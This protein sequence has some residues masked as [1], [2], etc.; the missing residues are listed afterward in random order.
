MLLLEDSAG[1]HADAVANRAA[2]FRSLQRPEQTGFSRMVMKSVANANIV[3]PN[4]ILLGRRSVYSPDLERLSRVATRTLRGLFYLTSGHRLPDDYI[5]RATVI[6]D[7]D[8]QDVNFRQTLGAAVGN[9]STKIGANVL[10]YWVH[11]LPESP[12]WS[13]WL[14]RYYEADSFA[15]LT[16]AKEHAP[17]QASV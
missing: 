15:G 3:T 11:F 16:L 6:T 13:A 7:A 10:E 1:D 12:D 5:V 17:P 4:G 2:F 9:P 14:F 8:M